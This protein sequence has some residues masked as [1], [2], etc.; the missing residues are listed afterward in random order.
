M[1]V[2]LQRD[3]YAVVAAAQDDNAAFTLDTIKCQA[4]KVWFQ[5][6]VAASFTGTY[7]FYGSIDGVRWTPLTL[8][9]ALL[10]H[11]SAAGVVL[12][13]NTIAAT[14]F[15]GNFALCL[16][17]VPTFLQIRGTRSAGGATGNLQVL[18]AAR[19]D[20]DAF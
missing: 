11:A 2:A 16:S 15:V 19:E 10:V 18:A 3:T 9:S 4:D 8:P 14:A 12:S 13:G 20:G 17:D 5:F 7:A 1:T 6:F